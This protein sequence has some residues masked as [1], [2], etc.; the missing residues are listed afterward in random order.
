M[1][2]PGCAASAGRPAAV[3]D[4]PAAAVLS[5]HDPAAAVRLPDHHHAPLLPDDDHV[6]HDDHDAPD[7]PVGRG[8]VRHGRYCRLRYVRLLRRGLLPVDSVRRHVSVRLVAAGHHRER[9]H[10]LLGRGER[11]RL[12]V[13]DLELSVCDSYCCYQASVSTSSATFPSYSTWSYT[14]TCTAYPSCAVEVQG[15]SVVPTST[16]TTTTTSST[17]TTTTL[18]TIPSVVG[19]Y[20][21]GGTVVSDTCGYYGAGSYL[22]IPF[23]VTYQSGSSLLGTI[24]SGSMSSSG[25]VNAGGSWYLISNSVCDSYCCYQASVSTSS[26]TFPSYSTW[27]YAGR[28]PPTRAAPSRSRARP[29]RTDRQPA[30]SGGTTVH[31]ANAGRGARH[32]NVSFLRSRARRVGHDHTPPC[33]GATR[34]ATRRDPYRRLGRIQ[35]TGGSPT[36]P[37]PVRVFGGQ[38]RVF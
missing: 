8:V 35:V 34:P 22:S 37:G 21:M 38:I 13:P 2:G 32:R 7:H 30:A 9:Q 33:S 15:T 25:A 6:Q 1:P 12:L 18:P 5:A 10:E 27:S 17:T 19:S 29:S 16:T 28:V 31:A 23:G 36:N 14:E 11:G 26:A 24:G 3:C 20:V 4:V